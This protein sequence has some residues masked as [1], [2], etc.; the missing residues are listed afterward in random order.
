MEEAASIYNDILFFRYLMRD[1]GEWRKQPLY[2][3]TFFFSGI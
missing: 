2:I 3:M 1:G